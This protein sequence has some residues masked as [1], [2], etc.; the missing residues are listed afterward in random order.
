MSPASSDQGD[1]PASE[2]ASATIRLPREAG[3]ETTIRLPREATAAAGVRVPHE[4]AGSGRRMG[5]EAA[6]AATAVRLPEEL[7]YRLR[8]IGAEPPDGVPVPLAQPDRH[9]RRRGAF[10]VKAAVFV[11]LAALAVL[12]LQAFVIQPYAV[13]GNAMSPTLRAGDRIL[14]VKAGLLAGG[15]HSGEIVVLRPPQSLPCTVTGA[16]GGD[17][18][19]R[20]VALPG[21]TIWSVGQTIFVDGRPLSE[22]GWYNPGFGQVGSTP[23]RSTTLASDQL[24]VMADN[25]S[26]GCDS[27]DFGPISK[28]SIVG[29]G[30]AL[31]GRDG[32]LAFGKL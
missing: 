16:T 18:V 19:L 29:E 17:L 12:L 26:D 5:G 22:R 30:I 3:T 1:S 13:P 32:H 25:R 21:E 23:V 6:A 2:A 11:A 7:D 14:V 10:L 27:R 31:V 28:S 15:V 20:V 24:F 9:Q 8:G 4:A